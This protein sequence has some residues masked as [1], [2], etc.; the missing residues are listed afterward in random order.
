MFVMRIDFAMYS[1]SISQFVLL[2][3]VSNVYS[4]HSGV[5]Q[6]GALS[7][8]LF[9]IFVAELEDLFLEEGVTLHAWL[10]ICYK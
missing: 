3:L 10:Y 9:N 7:P 1:P 2:F 5:P 4:L 8:T 6:G